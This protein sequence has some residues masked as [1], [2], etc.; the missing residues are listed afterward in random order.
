MFKHL[1][2]KQKTLAGISGFHKVEL[3]HNEKHIEIYGEN[4]NIKMEKN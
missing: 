3:Q 4:H 2:S 1:K